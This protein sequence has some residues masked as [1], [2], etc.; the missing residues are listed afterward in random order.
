MI[1]KTGLR[2][3]FP[4]SSSGGWVMRQWLHSLQDDMRSVHVNAGRHRGQEV[5]DWGRGDCLDCSGDCGAAVAWCQLVKHAPG[6]HFEPF[7]LSRRLIEEAVSER[8]LLEMYALEKKKYR[9]G[10]SF[11][12]FRRS[13]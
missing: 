6:R 11:C 7:A 12:F 4:I 2:A 1:Y 13:T 9:R 5:G 10:Q 8:S 3:L